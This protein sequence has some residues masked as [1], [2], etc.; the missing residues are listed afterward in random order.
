MAVKEAEE[1]EDVTEENAEIENMVWNIISKG[2][3]SKSCVLKAFAVK[4]WLIPLVDTPWT[5]QFALDWHSMDISL[6]SKL[7]ESSFYRC[8]WAVQHLADYRLTV[9]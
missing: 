4:G 8:K 7:G 2:W 9:D 6:I 5:L 3:S 1:D